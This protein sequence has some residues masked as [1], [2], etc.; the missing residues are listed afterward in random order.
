MEN[1]EEERLN[2]EDL[3]DSSAENE[4]GE[5]PAPL[6]EESAAAAEKQDDLLEEDFRDGEESPEEPP[7]ESPEETGKETGQFRTL[8]V[9]V[10]VFLVVGALVS[11][12]IVVYQARVSENFSTAIE[13][14]FAARTGTGPGE[15]YGP[16]EDRQWQHLEYR[17]FV[18]HIAGNGG[19]DRIMMYDV[20][21]EFPD[22]QSFDEDQRRQLRIA[23]YRISKEVVS[24]MNIRTTP[25]RMVRREMERRILEATAGD[26]VKAV[27]FTRFVVI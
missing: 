12:G 16:G 26:S 7:E 25:S 4:G 5:K 20:T 8:L 15:P 14:L 19:K 11:T 13:N 22:T 24:E 21:L 10:S 27:Y 18:V 1:N 17:D 3:S 6:E 23:L 2:P 9:A